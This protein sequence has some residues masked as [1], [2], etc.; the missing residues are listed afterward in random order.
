MAQYTFFQHR[1]CEYF[2][3]HQ[4]IAADQFNCLFCYCPFYLSE[5]K[6]PGNPVYLPT[7]QKDCSS[8]NFP[9]SKENYYTIISKINKIT[10]ELTEM[11]DIR[12]AAIDLDHTLLKE[13]DHIEDRVAAIFPKLKECGCITIIATAR[14]LC[15][16]YAFVKLLQPDYLICDNGARTYNLKNGNFELIHATPIPR[17]AKNYIL[18]KLEKYDNI[19]FLLHLGNCLYYTMKYADVDGPHNTELNAE[20]ILKEHHDWPGFQ[21]K[22]INNVSELPRDEEIYRIYFDVFGDVQALTKEF[23]SIEEKFPGV[24][25][26]SSYQGTFEFGATDKAKALSEL[27]KELQIPIECILA[28]G[29]SIADKPMIEYAGIGVAVEN[30]IDEVKAIADYI[31]PSVFEEGVVQFLEQHLFKRV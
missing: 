14:S 28:V 24:K 6:C 7:G 3:C 13:F 8:C 20:R 1:L 2:P 12:L 27:N 22:K 17:D 25:F 5:K 29:D 21:I 4:G 23:D 9:H 30:A 18:D 15:E 16:A 19:N 10:K 26:L 11:L 31:C